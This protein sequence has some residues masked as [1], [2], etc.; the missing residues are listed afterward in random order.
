MTVRVRR[1]ATLVAAFATGSS[2]A[3]PWVPPGDVQ[4]R[5][6]LALL[7]DSNRIDVPL[8][9]WPIARVDIDHAV[10]SLDDSTLDAAESAALDRI[11]R[12]IRSEEEPLGITS[13]AAM[14]DK[15]ATIR[16]F[17][18]TPRE[19]AQ[20]EGGLEWNSGT[21]FGALHVTGTSAPQDGQSLRPDGTWVGSRIGNWNLSAG[22]MDRWWGPGQEGSLILS[23]N[24]RPMPGVSLDRATSEPFR[25]RWLHWLGPWTYSMFLSRMEGGRADVSNALF[26]G[27]RFTFRPLSGLELGI[28]RTA[29]F[30]GSGRQCSLNSVKD[31]LVGSDNSG[32]NVSPRDE[33]GNQM[34]GFDARVTPSPRIP[35]SLYTQ[36]IGEDQQAGVPFKYLG[37]FGVESWRALDAGSLVRVHAEFADTACSWYRSTP[38]FGCA[39]TQHVFDVE[40][41]RYRGRSIGDSIDADGRELSLG[42]ELDEARGAQWVALVRRVDLDRGG[43]VDPR[44]QVS[45]VPRREWLADLQYQR[46]VALGRITAGLGLEDDREL[47]TG[48]TVSSGNGFVRLEH[49]FTP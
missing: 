12:W 32:D 47:L 22:W 38:I 39:Y 40:G 37:L 16:T 49:V 27:Q 20:L 5:A 19:S 3:G 28:S 41:Y 11:T 1:I 29:Q 46:D 2:L 21:W 43:A 15:P 9:T 30:C 45:S 14:S 42:I 26:F 23:T 25:S 10:G 44:N 18:S 17:A 4:I 36:W 33:P 6:D 24:A 34:A 7:V 31:M 8:S 13:T 35:L 48:R